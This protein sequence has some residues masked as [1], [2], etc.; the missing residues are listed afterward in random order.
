[1]GTDTLPAKDQAVDRL[2]DPML[3]WRLLIGVIAVATILGC[4]VC[5]TI[6]YLNER[7][8]LTDFP[9][10]EPVVK[11]VPPHY[12]FSIYGVSE[13]HGVTVSPDGRRIY[14][15][16]TG[17]QRALKIFDRD[18]QALGSFTPPKVSVF[19]RAPDYVA[20]DRLGRL[21]VSDRIR[22]TIDIY[23]A[24]GSYIGE[25]PPPELIDE[26]PGLGHTLHRGTAADSAPTWG[27]SAWQY[28]PVTNDIG[29]Y[30]ESGEFIEKFPKPGGKFWSPLGV[31]FDPNGYFYVTDVTGDHHRVIVFD[32]EGQPIRQF[33][34]TGE[35]F[36]QFLFPNSAIS[37]G[38]GWIY[39]SDGNNGRIQ[40]FSKV[41][42]L[43]FALGRSSG[44]AALN[45]PRGIALDDSNRLYVVDTVGQHVLVFDVSDQPRLLF[46]FGESGW[47]DGQFGYP[48]AIAVDRTGRLY[49]TD[50][51]NN[52]VQVW[53]Y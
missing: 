20:L 6:Y 41:G 8:P 14:V 11:A 22:H 25:F 45:L 52:R 50:R 44:D 3:P 42:R 10:V 4:V 13:P 2:P 53:S 35:A 31:A 27:G 47:G 24:D 12:L 51:V 5:A 32:T 29:L 33:G 43:R 15:V 34:R 16:E 49:I 21:F 26:L 38:R 17:G 9:I 7:T 18:G 37:N 23:A 46:T 39:V 40:A 28:D 30:T 36:G 19:S 1:M 48:T